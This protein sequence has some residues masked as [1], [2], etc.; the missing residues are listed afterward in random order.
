VVTHRRAR[1]EWLKRRKAK[2]VNSSLNALVPAVD[3]AAEKDLR[4]KDALVAVEKASAALEEVESTH[5]LAS[6]DNVAAE[7]QLQSARES[8][9]R[10]RLL[11]SNDSGGEAVCGHCGQTV[12][13]SHAEQYLLR[14]SD[15]V[16]EAEAA[17]FE[18][19]KTADAKNQQLKEH[20]DELDRLKT[21]LP[22]SRRNRVAAALD[23]RVETRS[24]RLVRC[25][26]SCIFYA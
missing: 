2:I 26:R 21:S 16:R 6:D 14:L 20:R 3:A 17:A 24:R 11:T 13:P 18:S 1:T 12:G 4:V 19:K 5:R 9:Q 22:K 15:N 25:Y 23:E 8:E 7:R 10:F